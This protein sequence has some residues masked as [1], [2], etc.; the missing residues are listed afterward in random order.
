MGQSE[1]AGPKGQ[2]MKVK[3][4]IVIIKNTKRCGYLVNVDGDRY[5]D[6]NTSQD[7]DQARGFFSF[8]H[9]ESVGHKIWLSHT[10]LE[11]DIKEVGRDPGDGIA[12]QAIIEV[13][14]SM[15]KE[16]NADHIHMSYRPDPGHYRPRFTVT[17]VDKDMFQLSRSGKTPHEAYNRIVVDHKRGEAHQ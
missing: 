15:A 7:I 4:W 13:F 16:G 6:P 1:M 3:R 8:D 11:Y 17:L 9:A 5:H 10:G 14:E 12:N 2:S